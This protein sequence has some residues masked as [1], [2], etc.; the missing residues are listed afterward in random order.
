MTVID[1]PTSS[2]PSPN[3]LFCVLWPSLNPDICEILMIISS[4]LPVIGLKNP[5]INL[6]WWDVREIIQF[7]HSQ[8]QVTEKSFLS[9]S[10]TG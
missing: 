9:F 5:L 4:L 7:L 3:K 10:P 2:S 1:S 8:T 6:V